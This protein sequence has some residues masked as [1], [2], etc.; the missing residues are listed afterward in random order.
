MNLVQHL[1]Q[2]LRLLTRARLGSVK[3]NTPVTCV[4]HRHGGRIGTQRA[5]SMHPIGVRTHSSTPLLSSPSCSVCASHFYIWPHQ[6]RT[7]HPSNHAQNLLLP[8]FHP[9]SKK[10]NQAFRKTN[11]C[12]ICP[13]FHPQAHLLG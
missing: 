6:K 9:P 1:L 13:F 10:T 12:P 5:C 11:C 7:N 2:Q 4:M 3:Y 8:F